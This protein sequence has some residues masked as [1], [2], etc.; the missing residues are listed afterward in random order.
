MILL[1]L[2]SL[3]LLSFL[4]L[5]F[6]LPSSRGIRRSSFVTRGYCHD[7]E[8]VRPGN[9]EFGSVALGNV[10]LF[11]SVVCSMSVIELL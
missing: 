10:E 7:F 3:V 9:V 1:L 8:Y 4:P 11:G 5:L 2:F 6:P